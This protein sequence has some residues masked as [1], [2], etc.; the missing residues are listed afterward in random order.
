MSTPRLPGIRLCMP[1]PKMPK[2]HARARDSSPPR[3][4]FFWWI[5]GWN[6]ATAAATSCL[7]P[8]E[9]DASVGAAKP[10]RIRQHAAECH[11]VASL[12]H[13]RHIGECRIHGLDVGALA[14]ESVL[15]HQHRVDRLLDACGAKRMAG[16]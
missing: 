7:Q 16:K 12:A 15:H 14:D 5:A 9:H 13:N 2:H 11:V 6:P 10:E 3:G 4:C 8:L 1:N